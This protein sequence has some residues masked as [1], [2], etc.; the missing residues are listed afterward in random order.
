LFRL[1]SRRDN[2]RRI[3]TIA[4]ITAKQTTMVSEVTPSTFRK[5]DMGRLRVASR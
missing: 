1:F 3:S 5:I 4:K 2:L